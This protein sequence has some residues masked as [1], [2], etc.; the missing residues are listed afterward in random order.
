MSSTSLTTRERVWLPLEY[1][2]TVGPLQGVT[3]EGLRSALI[4]LHATDPTH[5]AV[6]RLDRAGARWEH[7]DAA[8]FAR[9]VQD[10]VT[11][12]GGLDIVAA[13]QALQHEPRAHHPVRMLV[14]PDF[15]ALKISH[16]YGDAGPVNTLLRELVKAAAEGRAAAVKP[17]LRHRSALLTAWFKQ[18]AFQ[19]GR[20]KQG[21][22][23]PRPPR[24]VAEPMKPWKN[25]IVWRTTRSAEALVQMRKWRDEHAP[26]VTTSAIT[27]AA[28]AAALRDLGANPNL[29]GAIFLA[30]ARR[31]LDKG[32]EIDSDFCMGMWLSP[33]DMTDP[34][35]I[36]RLIKAELTVPR[37]L[38]VMVLEETKILAGGTKGMPDPFPDEIAVNTRA[39]HTF[40]NQ[41][42]HDGLSDLPWTAEPG[43]RYNFSVPTLCEP[44]GIALAT[45]E[46]NGVLHL[47]ATFHAST[48]D[49][50]LIAKALDLVCTDPA[51]LIM[52]GR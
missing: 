12:A 34:A 25:E 15:V 26:G 3:V 42:R 33:D 51:G 37:I 27:F 8:A 16:S 9:Y 4:G 40:S 7:M 1:V 43:E 50:A 47:D 21:L 41:G 22:N 28:F 32:V 30:D 10:A 2:R 39:R 14:G 13:T 17:S 38:S 44:D 19:P 18:I 31:F 52:A 20:W 6:S 24:P 5:R 46:M 45:T 36:H 35:S 11:D 29:D 49:P 48:F 23:F